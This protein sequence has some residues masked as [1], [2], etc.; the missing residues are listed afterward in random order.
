M[1]DSERGRY[2]SSTAQVR[3][4]LGGSSCPVPLENSA[5]V[6]DL[7]VLLPGFDVI[8]RPGVPNLGS[9]LCGHGCGRLEGVSL[10][11]VLA[12]KRGVGWRSRTCLGWGMRSLV[13]RS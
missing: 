10:G 8:R 6:L 9:D 11:G 7:A 1:G 3:A 4:R 12:G 5:E 13:S 2:R